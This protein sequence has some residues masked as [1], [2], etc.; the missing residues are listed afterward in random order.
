M[1]LMRL[2]PAGLWAGISATSSFLSWQ[3]ATPARAALIVSGVAG[4]VTEGQRREAFVAL[5]GNVTRG[6]V[7]MP[8]GGGRGCSMQVI[9]SFCAAGRSS[10]RL[11]NGS[12]DFSADRRGHRGDFQG[13]GLSAV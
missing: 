13:R 6:A 1:V 4:L 5:I 10:V 8:R 2:S 9:G 3:A 11:W 12:P 7:V